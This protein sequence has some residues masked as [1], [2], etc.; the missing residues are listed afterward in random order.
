MRHG[1][2]HAGLTFHDEL[3]LALEAA[4]EGGEVR[5]G[6]EI[7]EDECD[8]EHRGEDGD[9][10][11]ALLARRVPEQRQR[12][13]DAGGAEV[14][15]G[16]R[17]AH[18]DAERGGGAGAGPL[19]VEHGGEEGEREAHEERGV[20]LHIVREFEELMMH[21]ERAARRERRGP[22]AP[23][24]REQREGDDCDGRERRRDAAPGLDDGLLGLRH[25]AQLHDGI[26]GRE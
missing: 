15:G 2:G 20:L 14:F 4:L 23:E 22:A 21:R 1:S 6:G 7:H 9:A 11:P 5:E 24:I 25:T 3:H 12:D 8:R 16:E 17:E 26:G 10:R 13:E 18:G 19:P